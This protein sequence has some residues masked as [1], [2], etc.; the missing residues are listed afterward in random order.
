MSLFNHLL[1]SS[2]FYHQQPNPNNRFIVSSL[3]PSAPYH[4]P[5]DDPS[6]PKWSLVHVTFREKFKYP[7]T[8][9][10]LREL[11]EKKDGLEGLMMLKQT[12]L[13]VS[14]VEE[15]EWEYLMKW[16]EEKEK[17]LDEVDG[18][19]EKEGEGA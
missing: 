3:N 19:K 5:R 12:R 9:T 6:N 1:S 8:L 10:T 11:A 16:R 13:S 7:I 4:D 15:G 2:Y 18:A 17:E 14:K